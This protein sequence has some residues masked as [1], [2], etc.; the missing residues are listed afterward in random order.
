[1]DKRAV[2]SVETND[3]ICDYGWGI[4]LCLILLFCLSMGALYFASSRDLN[5]TSPV[6]TVGLQMIWYLLGSLLASLIMHVSERQLL[7]WATVGYYCGLAGLVLVLFFYSRAYFIQTGAK[8]WFAIGPL[9]F[10]PAEVMKPFYILMMSRLLVEDYHR[11]LHE[12][13]QDDW[14][15]LKKMLGYT[16]PIIILLKFIHDLGTTM[17]FVAI[18]AGCLLVSQCRSKFLWRLFL[19]AGTVGAGLVWAATSSGGQ[20]LLTHLGFKA[21]QFARINS[22]INPSGDTSGQSYQLWQSMTAIGSGRIWGIGFHHQSVYVPVRESDMIFSV[23]GETTGFVGSVVVLGIFMYLIYLVV[24]AALTSH[25]LLYVYVSIGVAVMLVFHLFEN[26]GMTVG[27]LP[28]TGIPL[29]FMSQ[30][31][32]ALLGN[33][34][35][36]GLVLSAQYRNFR[37]IFSL[38]NKFY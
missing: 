27:L 15:L 13:A 28:L 35:G 4:V 16:L 37:S 34:M 9:T 38:P 33:F 12:R 32:S 31:G 5:P 23:I 21:Y 2:N 14:R 24:Q 22:W 8:S 11:G 18:L 20:Q 6:K 30:G 10:Q 25:Q 19:S 7:Q 17:V 36:I 26:V 29:P 1:M 3:R